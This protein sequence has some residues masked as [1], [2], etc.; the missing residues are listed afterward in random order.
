MARGRNFPMSGQHWRDAQG[1]FKSDWASAWLIGM[2][3]TLVA[4]F[5]TLLFAGRL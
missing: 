1:T 5:L 2:A 3:L 4:I